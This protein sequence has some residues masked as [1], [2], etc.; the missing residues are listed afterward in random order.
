LY[1]TGEVNA[2]RLP[3]VVLIYAD[4][5][6]YG[7][8][9]CYGSGISTPNIDQIAREG[10]RFTHFYSASPVCSPSRAALMT[11]RYPVRVG[12]PSVLFPSDTYGLPPNEM[13]MAEVLKTSQYK[14]MCIGK[15]HLGSLPQYLPT[16][17]GF[18][19]FFGMLCSNDQE[20]TVLLHDAQVIEE[21]AQQD[22][23]TER[24]TEQAID[25]IRRSNDAPFFLYLAHTFPHIPLA[26]SPRFLGKSGMGLYADVV[27]ELDWST[28]QVLQ[29]LKDNNVD[30]HTLVLFSSDNGPW[31]QGSSG[32]LR[33]RK[34]ETWDGGMRMPFLAR[35]PGKIP[36][37]TVFRGVATAMDVLPTVA[38]LTGSALPPNKLDGVD[39]SP[40]LTG[41]KVQVARDAF[42]FMDGWNIQCA[43]VG[44][45]KL[46]VAR[47]NS[48]AW[49]PSPA[50]GIKNLPL[51]RSE[52]YN[53]ERDVDESYDAALQ[54]PQVAAKIRS[55]MEALIATFPLPVQDV[56]RATM[57]VKVFDTPA[58]ALPVERS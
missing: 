36:A 37:G 29:S 51:S 6:G 15:W 25:F 57:N 35:Y 50:G 48:P 9:S 12:I 58:G 32:R 43:R 30:E 31:F 3:N 19:E 21:P 23:L 27:Q 47:Y 28:A 11:G 34:G 10:M 52:L 54:H 18:D 41:E 5:L 49:A 13:T 17:R 33:G 22:T 7:D 45:W 38:A 55:R 4:D 14:T 26:T 1:G 8:L 2:Q 42:L 20:P 53:L 40:I 46:H 44:R 16:N 39:I 24:Y 56:W